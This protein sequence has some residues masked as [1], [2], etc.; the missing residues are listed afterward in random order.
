M[1][2]RLLLVLFIAMGISVPAALAQHDP[3]AVH[4]HAHDDQ[5]H[6]DQAHDEHAHGA[7]HEATF[8]DIDPLSMAGS[9]VNFVLLL[10]VLFLLLRKSL[11]EFLANRRAAVVTGMEE[12]KRL[13]AE[14]DAKYKEY[15]ERID[16][17][18]AELERLREELRR[19][20]MDE[21]D[22]IVVEANRKAS[23]MHEEARFLIE[24]RMKQLRQDLT[25]E[26]IEAAVRAAEDVLM[27]G[28]GGQDQERLAKEYLG[29]IR[30][31]VAKSAEVASTLGE[32]R[33]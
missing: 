12:A 2:S 4:D 6:D 11:P 16:N 18:D 31:S 33:G 24:Q 20:G 15:S 22:R 1:L 3:H 14:A 7:H 17:L 29:T 5:A 32:K 25:R 27:K 8:A 10:G 23:K 21:R 9:V 28:T 13:K 26:A 30:S 19:A